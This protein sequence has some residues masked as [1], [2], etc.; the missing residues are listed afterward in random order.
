MNPLDNFYVDAT[1]SEGNLKVVTDA[2]DYSPVMSTIGVN[3]G[4]WYCEIKMINDGGTDNEFL[5]G[6]VSTQAT[7]TNEEVGNDATGYGYYGNDGN[8]RT[9]NSSS[10]YGDTYTEGDIVSIALNL[11]DN[12]LKFYKNG[13][14]Q[15]SGTA[16]SITAAAS[17]PLGNYFFALTHW[18]NTAG[19]FEV[20]FGNPT[21][22]ISSG[23]SDADG[24]GNFEYA[25]PSGYFALC[26]KNLAEYG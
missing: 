23:N 26:T 5:V 21:F 18:G 19:T 25:V 16:I 3:S 4:K 8:S 10:S 1:Y 20:N 7:G 15:N 14:V 13:T 24:Y 2:A 6:I 11:D 9:G 17:T 22:S 12:E